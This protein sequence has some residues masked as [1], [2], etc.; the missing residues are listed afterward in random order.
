MTI[1][2]DLMSGSIITTRI[3][4]ARNLRGYP[5]RITDVSTAKSIIKKVIFLSLLLTYFKCMKKSMNLSYFKRQ[6]FLTVILL[7]H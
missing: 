6:M 1:T 5:F 2:P 4:L 7:L 3:R